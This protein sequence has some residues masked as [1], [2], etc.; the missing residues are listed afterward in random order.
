MS[1][2][3]LISLG[4]GSPGAIKQFL[5]FGLEL[6]ALV[7]VPNVVGETQAQGTTDLQSAGFVVVVQSAYSPTVLAGLVISQQPVGGSSVVAGSTVI[8]IVSLGPQ[9]IAPANFSGGFLYEYERHAQSRARRRREEEE[10]AAEAALLQDVK[11]R[12]I[13]AFLH[14]QEQQDAER[15]DGERLRLLAVQYAKEKDSQALADRVKIAYVRLLNQGNH[16]AIEAFR[17]EM[18]R[19]LEEEEFAVLMI[20]LEE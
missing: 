13:A 8:I 4:I 11:D 12:E 9:P 5:T 15:A 16:S 20:L 1:D 3:F 19:A 14:A 10:A 17:R 2:S 6:A 18:D 7:S